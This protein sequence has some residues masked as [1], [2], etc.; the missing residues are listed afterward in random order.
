M[1]KKE[2]KIEKP[3]KEQR[4]L[5]MPKIQPIIDE[6]RASLVPKSAFTPVPQ[7]AIDEQVMLE[8]INRLF[9]DLYF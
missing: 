8:Q 3:Q 4:I 7:R 1:K 9:K 6:A 5:K 2:K